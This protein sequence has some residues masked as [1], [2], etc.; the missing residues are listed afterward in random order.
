MR[1]GGG[2]QPALLSPL[3]WPRCHERPAQLGSKQEEN[4][5]R[6]Q[7]SAICPGESWPPCPGVPEETMAA[8]NLWLSAG[9]CYMTAPGWGPG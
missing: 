6:D 3:L 4:L 5:L 8:P 7:G 9:P 2:A 1:R